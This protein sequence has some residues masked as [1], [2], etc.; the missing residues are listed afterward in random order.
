MGK[1]RYKLIEAILVEEDL[2]AVRPFSHVAPRCAP[3]ILRMLEQ[4]A[5][6]PRENPFSKFQEFN[7]VIHHVGCLYLVKYEPT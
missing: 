2:G 5:E 3:E 6:V 4:D 1:S 7:G